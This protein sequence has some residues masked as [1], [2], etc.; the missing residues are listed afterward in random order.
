M[1]AAAVLIHHGLHLAASLEMLERARGQRVRWS[2]IYYLEAFL[3]GQLRQIPQALEAITVA[4]R[5]RPGY[6]PYRTLER[7][8]VRLSR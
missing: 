7:E 3:R 6:A 4:M 2:R 8:L 5:L 1:E